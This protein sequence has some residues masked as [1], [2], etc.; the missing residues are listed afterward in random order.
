MHHLKRTL[1]FLLLGQLAS[2]SLAAPALPEALVAEWISGATYPADHYT[3]EGFRSASGSSERLLIRKDGSYEL[4]RLTSGAIP[5]Y[6][7]SRM[8]ACETMDFMWEKGTV[9]VKGNQ[10]ILTPSTGKKRN[11]ATPHNHNN[12]CTVFAGTEGTFQPTPKTL[13]YSIKNGTLQLASRE[14]TSTYQSRKAEAKTASSTAKIEASILGEWTSGSVS[15]L[16]YQN[17]ATGQWTSGGGTSTLLKLNANGT[18]AKTGLLVI[19]TYS[20]TSKVFVQEEGT[21]VQKGNQL[22][23]TPSKSKSMGYTCSPSNSFEEN[24]KVKPSSATF[25]LDNSGVL[26]LTSGDGTTRYNRAPGTSGSTSTSPSNTANSGTSPSTGSS[27]A[28]AVVRAIRTDGSGNWNGILRADGETLKISITLDEDHRGLYGT[29]FMGEDYVG[30]VQGNRAEGT[31]KLVLND[32]NE[33]TFLV[34][35]TFEENPENPR[36]PID[37]FMG[38]FQATNLQEEN[39][40]SG[41]LELTRP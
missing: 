30:Y 13:N 9:S 15:M 26:S 39:L 1:P 2:C 20:C 36:Y 18:Y 29:I 37:H 32:D 19:T 35:G 41:T 23:F 34:T 38:E 7:G 17:L 22:N 11:G 27:S 14:A 12:G 4:A 5:G 33:T 40:G 31:L 25:S 8:I 28:P 10:L 16:E 3:L 6:F 24:G 21:V